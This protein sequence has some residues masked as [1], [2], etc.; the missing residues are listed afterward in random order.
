VIRLSKLTYTHERVCQY[1]QDCVEAIAKVNF[2]TL[3][4][5]YNRW[6]S[7]CLSKVRYLAHCGLL[8]KLRFD[9]SE[10]S[11][12]FLFSPSL[13]KRISDLLDESEP[14]EEQAA[15]AWIEKLIQC[16]LDAHTELGQLEAA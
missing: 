8:S 15:K 9:G 14:T 10:A 7:S 11:D 2:P 6:D 13:A 5:P 16:T 12:Y 3:D 4:P 1:L